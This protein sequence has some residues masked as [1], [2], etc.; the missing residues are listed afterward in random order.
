MGMGELHDEKLDF[1]PSPPCCPV[2][3]VSYGT[4]VDSSSVDERITMAPVEEAVSE[5]VEERSLV[6]KSL[7]G[8]IGTITLDN[9]PKHNA[10]GA[11]LI[12]ELLLALSDL[13]NA[14]ARAIVL[15]A[16]KGAK[17]WSAGHDVRELPTNGRDPLTYD[18]PLR[19]V[20]RV[21]KESPTPIIAMVEGGVWGGA[22][23]VVMSCD[24]VIAAE[25]TTFAITPAKL[26]VPYDIEGTL[27]FMQSV[28]LPVIKE[29]LFTAQPMTADRALRVGLINQVVPAEHLESATR[30]LAG[31]M[32]RNSPLVISLLKE[33]LRVLGEA[34]PLNPEG[35][36][37]IQAIRRRIYDS[38]DYQEGIRAFFERRAPKFEGR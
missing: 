33:Q 12:G 23:E 38:A 17:V 25:G 34:H 6:E 37:R 24:I 27:S 20:V 19:R 15:R 26:G 10:L 29:M 11:A 30:E 9:P 31:Y 16:Y 22:C 28:S 2:D 36:Q 21:I 3:A 32:I 35:F 1:A 14:G 5:S 7:D 13:T 4:S 18:D 8:N